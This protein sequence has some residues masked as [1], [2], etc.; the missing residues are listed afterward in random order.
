MSENFHRAVDDLD[1]GGP[2]NFQDARAVLLDEVRNGADPRRLVDAVNRVEMEPGHAG[3]QIQLATDRQGYL[4]IVPAQYA[5]N[6]PR[7]DAPPPQY[8][9]PPPQYYQQGPTGADVA[10]AAVAGGVAGLIIGSLLNHGRNNYY[11]RRPRY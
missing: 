9:A 8:D 5:N 7:Y 2:R 4:D 3:A 1:R 10:G 11:E 6:Q